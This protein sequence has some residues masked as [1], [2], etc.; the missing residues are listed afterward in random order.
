MK[1]YNPTKLVL[2]MPVM[3]SEADST[4]GLMISGHYAYTD[5]DGHPYVFESG[6][7]SYTRTDRQVIKCRYTFPMTTE[8]LGA[9]RTKQML[10]TWVEK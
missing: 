1:N 2:N 8:T 4:D 9:I 6:G 3:Y 5:S 10:N 7:T